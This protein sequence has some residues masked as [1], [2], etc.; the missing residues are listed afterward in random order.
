MMRTA[1]FND[2]ENFRHNICGLFAPPSGEPFRH[3]D[4]TRR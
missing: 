1:I 3:R 4:F 2:G